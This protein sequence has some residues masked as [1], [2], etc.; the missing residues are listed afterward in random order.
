MGKLQTDR[1]QYKAR[2]NKKMKSLRLIVIIATWSLKLLSDFFEVADQDL[3]ETTPQEL[4]PADSIAIRS[5]EMA[6]MQDI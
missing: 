5:P 2:K 3:S 6:L 4:P 1:I